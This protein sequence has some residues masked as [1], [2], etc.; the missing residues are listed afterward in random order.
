MYNNLTRILPKIKKF[1]VTK[2]FFISINCDK[3][4]NFKNYNTYIIYKY[5]IISHLKVPI[6]GLYL[7]KANR[8]IIL[9]IYIPYTMRIDL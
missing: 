7:Y 6:R 4:F 8:K 2:Y 5:I 1:D 3:I 9:N